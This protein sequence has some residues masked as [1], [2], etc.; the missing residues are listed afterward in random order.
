MCDLKKELY[1]TMKAVLLLWENITSRLNEWGFKINSYNW[2]VANK[3]V[4]KKS[5]IFWHVNDLKILHEDPK[6][7]DDIAYKLRDRYGKESLLTIN[8]GKK[9]DYLGMLIEYI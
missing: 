5:T 8:R 7:V 6:V 1:K 2:C 4:E 9:H 3:E